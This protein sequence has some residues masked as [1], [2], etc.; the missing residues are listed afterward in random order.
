MKRRILFDR[1]Q[2]ARKGFGGRII[3]LTGARQTGKTTI[4]KYFS[5]YTYCSIDDP[6]Q[7][8]NY[9]QLTA[10]QWNRLYP[11]AILDEVQKEPDLIDSI[12]S[13]YEQF[14]E[15]R[16]I[17]LGSSQFLLQEKIK[18]SLAGR[19]TI[20]EIY[21][22]ILP[23]LMTKSWS[24]SV[25]PSFFVQYVENLQE[26]ETLFPSFTLDPEFA[27]KREAY[28]FYLRFGAYPVLTH[29]ITD[30][31]RREWLNMYVK[32]FLER[33]IRDLVS[34][35]DLEPFVKL[36]RYLALT[37]GELLNCASMATYGTWK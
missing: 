20:F 7:R 31:E 2:I 23:E 25:K 12:K 15:P 11:K 36:Q 37:T 1:A 19:C 22:L 17:L 33:D 5:S 16:Y 35:R 6:V 4:A 21:P 32:T 29:N 27:A 3:V 8:K 28:D 30:T 18:E 26:T 24:D 10:E 13:V 9:L 14:D 34:F